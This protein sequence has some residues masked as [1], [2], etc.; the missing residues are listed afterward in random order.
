MPYAYSSFFGGSH[1]YS[2]CFGFSPG[3]GLGPRLR[4]G[5]AGFSLRPFC[6]DAMLAWIWAATVFAARSI[7]A[8]SFAF[9]AAL[10][11]MAGAAGGVCDAAL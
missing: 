8:A 9:A 4:S 7:G 10:G 11:L 2:P 1:H 6:P 3:Q 5:S